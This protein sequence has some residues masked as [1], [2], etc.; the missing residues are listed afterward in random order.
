MCA[1]RSLRKRATINPVADLRGKGS[2]V[3]VRKWCAI[4]VSRRRAAAVVAARHRAD[5]RASVTNI[6][7]QGW[8]LA[9]ASIRD[10]IDFPAS[11]NLLRDD[12]EAEFLLEC[13]GNGA[14]DGVRLPTE[15]CN[16]LVYAFMVCWA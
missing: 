14:A 1:R 12:I 15:G 16:D 8:R 4:F 7:K 6:C 2:N 3:R 10:P 9:S 5:S 13:T 11:F